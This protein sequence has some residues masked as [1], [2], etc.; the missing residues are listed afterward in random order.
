MGKTPI[1]FVPGLA[2]NAKIFEFITLP[3]EKYELYFLEW[4]I[5]LSTNESIEEYAKRMCEK[6]THQNPV[7]IGVSFGGVMVQEMSKIIAT[8]KLIIISSIKSNQ[9]FPKRLKF[10]QITKAYKLFPTKIIINIEEYAKYFYGDYLK[11]RAELYKTYLSLRDPVYLQWAIYNVLHWQQKETTKDII[12]IHGTK[13]LVFPIK[14]INNSKQVEDGTHAM[15]L[16][17]GKMISKI[18]ETECFL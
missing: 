3:K 7:L 15:I 11:K 10:A 13:D 6:I 1:Y 14:N 9:E 18:L 17:K 8:K 4:L 5:P 2:A 12:H 16:T